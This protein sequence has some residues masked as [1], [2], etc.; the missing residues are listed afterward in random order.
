MLAGCASPVATPEPGVLSSL[1]IPTTLLCA[2]AEISSV[3]IRDARPATELEPSVVAELE[4]S[5]FLGGYPLSEWF[6]GSEDDSTVVIL[7]ALD[8]PLDLG[9]GEHRDFEIV[10]FS[11]DK[12]AALDVGALWSVS[13]A[14]NCA[15]RFDLGGLGA[16]GVMLDSDRLPRPEDT[17]LHL[18]VTEFACN[19]GEPA[20]DR[21]RL[22]D[23]SETSSAVRVVIGIS[24]GDGGSCP[25]NPPTPFSVELAEPLGKR[26][27]FDGSVV[28]SS[29]IAAP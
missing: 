22:V 2:D 4:F 18:L 14:S 11:T 3:A 1:P 29:E 5:D 20:T 8:E 17:T 19:S 27:V 21:V 10:K 16:G 26:H 23:L 9:I 28:P 6:I 12:P 24:P 15:M 25:S 13:L 7:R